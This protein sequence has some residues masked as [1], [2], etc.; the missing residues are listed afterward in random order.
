VELIKKSTESLVKYANDFWHLPEWTNYCLTTGDTKCE[1]HT[2]TL[3]DKDDSIRAIIPLIRDGEEFVFQKAFCPN[4]LVDEGSVNWMELTKLLKDYA[5][6]N[7]VKRI[8]I[9][10]YVP[11]FINHVQQVCVSTLIKSEVRKSYKSLMH[12]KLTN[13]EVINC[14]SDRITKEVRRAKEFYHLLATKRNGEAF[15]HYTDWIK[16]GLAFMVYARMGGELVGITLVTYYK[17]SA[18]YF[19]SGY[20]TKCRKLN[21]GHAMQGAVFNELERLGIQEYIL[22][23]ISNNQLLECKDG[24][25]RDINFFKSG[26][27]EAKPKIVSEYF[28]CP[29]YM[30]QT[31]I[32]RMKTYIGAELNEGSNITS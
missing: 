14:G 28:L 26:F 7:G 5:R 18:Y 32:K 12:S 3:V 9:N 17:G 30:K 13:C 21:I 29:E 2:L 24:K 22:G 19:I 25:N 10:G 8:A 4:I 15:R 11:T 20:L 27:G 31:M 23:D 1:E 16:K 6:V